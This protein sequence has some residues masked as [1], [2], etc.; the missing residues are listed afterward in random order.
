MGTA[1]RIVTAVVGL[2]LIL[3]SILK[4]HQLLTEPIIS[5]GL[6]ESW[7]FFLIQ[8]PLELGLGIWLL[9]GLF[10]KAVWLVAVISF[11]LFSLVTLQKIISG[12]ESCG[13]FGRVQVDPWITFLAVDISFLLALLIFRPKGRKL[14]PPPWP[15]AKHFFGVVIPTFVI[16]AVLMPVLIFNRP[17][18]K[19]DRYEV[20][21]HQEWTSL[22]PTSEEQTS[23]EQVSEEWPMLK[24][25]DIADSLRSKIVVVLF[26]HSGCPDCQEAISL[27]DR[28]SRQ[29]AG[30]EEA[31]RIAFIEVPPYGQDQDSPIPAETLCLTGRLDSSKQWYITTPLVVVILDGSVVKSWQEEVP[32]LDEILNAVFVGS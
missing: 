22:E 10:R 32:Q 16:M 21:R 31:V 6:W 13:C 8:I 1:N 5:R 11:G 27:Y 14:L 30:S 18:D 19:T 29:L 20:V 26:Y 4:I 15:S 12:A 7:E 23:Q 25:I 2:V 24:H 17:P 9:S 3:A 28:T